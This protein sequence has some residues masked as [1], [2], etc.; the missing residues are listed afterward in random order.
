[1]LGIPLQSALGVFGTNSI[2][3]VI[4]GFF[5]MQ[6]W[7]NRRVEFRRIFRWK[8]LV[9]LRCFPYS[10]TTT[11]NNK[12]NLQQTH[13]CD[14]GIIQKW[15]NANLGFFRP[16][17][18]IFRAI[19]R[20]GRKTQKRLV[21]LLTI[22]AASIKHG[23]YIVLGICLTNTSIKQIWWKSLDKLYWCCSYF[24]VMLWH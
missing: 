22:T 20:E 18:P 4:K 5:L 14:Q 13:F 6:M 3:L 24:N 11:Y 10:L 15:H 12:P 19:S 8:W 7:S 23:C 16:P 2:R 21:K 1:M 9:G 17:S